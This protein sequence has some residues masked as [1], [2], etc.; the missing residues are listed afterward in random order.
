MDGVLYNNNGVNKEACERICSV[1]MARNNFQPLHR[2]SLRVVSESKISHAPSRMDSS[3]KKAF[4]ELLDKTL[5]IVAGP[6]GSGK[7]FMAA[8]FCNMCLEGGEIILA[9]SKSI[10]AVRQLFARTII[11]TRSLDTSGCLIDRMVCTEA[12][13]ETPGS[14]NLALDKITEAMNFFFWREETQRALWNQRPLTSKESIYPKIKA[15]F[16]TFERL[17]EVIAGFARQF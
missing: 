13:P 2:K 3:R 15:L 7:S 5:S 17:H 16:T 4:C 14:G 9:T 8:T 10:A 6:L 12:V 1:L 11:S